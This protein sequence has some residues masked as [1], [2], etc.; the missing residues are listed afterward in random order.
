MRRLT[1]SFARRFQ[2]TNPLDLAA[3]LTPEQRAVQ[4]T[5]RHYAQT[6]LLPGIVQANRDGVFDRGI[7]RAMGGLGLLGTTVRPEHGGSDSGYVAYGLV[8]RE[9]ER[10]DSA[11][12]S[13]LSVQ[14]SLVLGPLQDWGSDEQKERWMPSLVA[15]ETV[16]CFGLTEPDQGS[17]PGGLRT[18]A[19]RDADGDWRLSGTK[20]WITN[21]P[22]ADLL[23]VWA[24]DSQDTMHGFL[25]ERGMS[26]LETTTIHGKLALRASE[27]GTIHMDSVRVPECNRLPGVEGLRGPFSCLNRAR[28]GIAWGAMGAA[29]DAFARA[30]DYTVGRKQFGKPL[31]GQQLVQR[32]LA[33]ANTEIA[34]GLQACY[35]VGQLLDDPTTDVAPEMVSMIK[36]NNAGKALTIA[37]DAR[38]MLGAN[39]VSDDYHVMRHAMNLEAVNTYEGT[40]D[41]HALLLG[42]AITGLPA[43]V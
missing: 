7:L 19:T 13:A 10:V 25:L 30:V 34:L 36:R 15:G 8:A 32:R 40:H 29:E 28:Y 43:F 22:I 26:G 41:I 42:R 39:G 18:R 6:E 3:L 11:Y 4:D 12:R 35:R 16:G 20:T 21:A 14:S 24:K 37:R 33:D 17:D 31:A 38:D 9:L 2:H 5:A 27:T 1:S 23:L